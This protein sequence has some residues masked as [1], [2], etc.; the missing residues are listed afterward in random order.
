MI[1]MTLFNYRT[2]TN[3]YIIIEL[4]QKFIWVFLDHLIEKAE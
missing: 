1:K 2:D 3:Y 4:A